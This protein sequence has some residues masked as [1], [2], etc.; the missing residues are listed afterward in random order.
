[1]S[2]LLLIR[3]GQASFGTDNYDRLSPI[4]QRQARLVGR[5]LA[6]Q[7]LGFDAWIAG[8][9]QRQQHTAQLAGEAF[10]KPPTLVVEPCF[11]EYHAD[12]LFKSFMPRVIDENPEI[13][14]KKSAIHADR[15]LFQRAFEQVMRHWLAG[16]AAAADADFEP[17]ADFKTRVAAGLAR[18]RNDYPRDS[19]LAL[20]SSGGPIAV[21]LGAALG[22]ADDTTIEL[23]WSVYNASIAELRSTK[24]GWRMLGFNDI[25]AQREAGDPALITFR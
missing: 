21:A 8:G 17:W 10:T 25:S 4:G 15:R 3:H 19:R 2:Q 9:L 23:N 11:N 14:A 7:G 6:A 13:A 20:F 16:S 5:Q 18:L 1:M 24:T 22:A 12:A